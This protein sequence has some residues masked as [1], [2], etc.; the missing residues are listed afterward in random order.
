MGYLL[1]LFIRMA[2]AERIYEL[3]S[4]M[5][6][7]N[8]VELLAAI[9]RDDVVKLTIAVEDEARIKRGMSSNVALLSLIHI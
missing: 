3:A 1:K 4:A 5:E 6:D 7:G 2:L 9:Q 8:I